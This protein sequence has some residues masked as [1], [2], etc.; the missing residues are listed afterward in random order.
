MTRAQAPRG[1]ADLVPPDS[2]LLSELETVARTLFDRYGYRRI[3]TPLFEQTELFLRSTG[4]ASDIVVQKQMYTFED[5]GERSL[6]LRPEWTPGVVRAFIEHR[7]DGSLPLPVR[8]WGIGPCFRYERPQK[9]RSR[10]FVQIDVEC[11]GSAEPMVDAEVI[12][13][14]A[15][16]FAQFGLEPQLLLNSMGC[17]DDRSRFA[18]A[19]RDR[20]AP[21]TDE[22]CGD[23]RERLRTNPPRVF[24]C[25]VATCR[26]LVAAE[27]P[28]STEFLC[29]DCSDHF[30]TIK[31]VLSGLGIGW[32]HA[33][34]LVRGLDYYT[35]TVFEFEMPALGARATVCAGGRYDGLVEELG[36]PSTPA[37]GF[38][39]GAAPTM[40]A[41]RE[42]KRAPASWRP[43]V[44]I[45]WLEGLGERA[46]ATAREL[47]DAGLRVIVSDEPKSMRAQL[48]A[49]GRHEASRAVILGP[50]EVERGMAAVRD[51]GS[52]EQTEVPLA[53]L[54]SSLREA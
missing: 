6:T 35:R 11:I 5:P 22:L 45:V 38:A 37:L 52:G 13:L 7:L 15:H 23:C 48:R 29:K 46:L 42:A 43:D 21:F 49:A 47:R 18:A 51:L 19:V 10:Q 27:A 12:A 26:T 34:E 39:I 20:L 50:R 16:F 17:P 31:D 40:V 4:E 14:G 2:E 30:D 33:P 54:S 32:K 28:P 41:L 36:G 44:Y 1:A 25:K 24:D 9:G 53:E 8:L 3:E